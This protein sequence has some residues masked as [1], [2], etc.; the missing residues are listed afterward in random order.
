MRKT[1]IQSIIIGFSPEQHSALAHDVKSAHSKSRV[2]KTALKP[3][4]FELFLKTTLV[5]V[6]FLKFNSKANFELLYKKLR[7]NNKDC[8]VV[9]M[10]EPGVKFL[11]GHSDHRVSKQSLVQ[12]CQVV[13]NPAYREFHLALQF[14]M[15]YVI[16]KK[17]F[18]RCKSL[19]NLSESRALRLVDS[20]N[21][22]IAFIAKGK[23]VHAN[24][25]F[26]VMFS[27]ESI[28][29]LKRFPLKKL[30]DP[31]QHE[32]FANYLACVARSSAFNADL[33]LSMRK[34][35]G[36]TF[37]AKIQASRA[38]T[39]GQ[40]CFQVWV[41]QRVQG[42]EEEVIP[43][44]KKLNIWDLP[45]EHAIE[46]DANPFDSVLSKDLS[47]ENN[48]ENSL[49]V[50]QNELLENDL[51]KL[52]LRKLYDPRN[53]LLNTAWVRLDVDPENF[54]MV[55]TLLSRNT[56]S[57]STAFSNFWDHMMF[58]LVLESLNLEALTGRSY[59]V[60]LSSGSI[61]SYDLMSW[62]YKRLKA[63]GEVS[64]KLT[65]VIDA[66]IPMNRIPQT[67]KVVSLLKKAGCHIALNNF[68]VDITPLFLFK[69]IKPELVIL[70]SQW[71]DEI[72]NKN[73]DGLFVKRF[74]KKLESLG[75]SVLIPQT[76]QK[77]QDRL[78]VLTG[79]SI[80]QEMSTQGCI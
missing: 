55:N 59:L 28:A 50:I 16:L 34:I 46:S 4:A 42:F 79:A 76:V 33:V 43:V 35:S 80:G 14:V 57:A 10:I 32:V 52:R 75:V 70:D 15:Q 24:I 65:F 21:H 3:D 62:L 66:E 45:T 38:V 64:K 6:I 31:D 40:L 47:V 78:F 36:V 30:I 61:A 49:E 20:N 18:R 17:D 19:L 67:R 71:M 29:E 53:R 74:V 69:H 56:T 51:I 7:A 72:K 77:D 39:N 1:T 25:P 8:V 11:A 48:V 2:N 54:R 5:D 26:L 27:A 22:A 23:F 12:K 37:N 60:T 63:L 13:H 9:E 41:E 58:K 73:D 44:T 68:S